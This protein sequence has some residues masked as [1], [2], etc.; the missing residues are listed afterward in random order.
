MTASTQ[1]LGV[2][3]WSDWA[4]R[5]RTPQA[6][7]GSFVFYLS[8]DVDGSVRDQIAAHYRAVT[9]LADPAPFVAA[10]FRQVAGVTLADDI[11]A[12]FNSVPA[13]LED[14]FPVQAHRVEYI[15]SAKAVSTTSPINRQDYLRARLEALREVRFLHQMIHGIADE[16]QQRLTDVIVETSAEP[17][18]GDPRT[19]V[20]VQVPRSGSAAVRAM[21]TAAARMDERVSVRGPLPVFSD[22]LTTLLAGHKEA[23]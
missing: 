14:I 7:I 13:Q 15:V 11:I 2:G 1:I 23:A 22:Q 16:C 10:K 6:S 8:T 5:K 9:E 12:R 3:R 19:R 17:D 20:I 21:L 4:L 18:V